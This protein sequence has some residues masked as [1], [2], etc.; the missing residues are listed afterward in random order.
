VERVRRQYFEF[1][2]SPSWCA[3]CTV[4]CPIELVEASQLF[5]TSLQFSVSV[6]SDTAYQLHSLDVRAAEAEPPPAAKLW[7]AA[8]AAAA[9]A[10]AAADVVL[11][12]RRGIRRFLFPISFEIA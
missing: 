1:W 12:C 3:L 2:F 6:V 11:L 10:A 5:N 7:R 9:A 4:H 8:V